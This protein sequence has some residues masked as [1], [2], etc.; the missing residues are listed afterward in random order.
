CKNRVYS[1]HFFPSDNEEEKERIAQSSQPQNSAASPFNPDFMAQRSSSFSRGRCVVG[2][3]RDMVGKSKEDDR[4]EKII[5]GL[6]RLG[7]NRR[8]INCNSLGPQYVCTTFWTIVCTNCSGVHREFTHRVKSISM[9]TFSTEEVNALQAGGNERARQ[10][11]FKAWDPVRHGFPESSNINRLRDFI[12]H[13]YVDR[14]FTGESPVDRLPRL[15]LS[16]KDDYH[17]RRGAEAIGERYGCR[18]RSGDRGTRYLY[19][20]IRSPSYLQEQ[21]K[22]PGFRT[23]SRFDVV[24]DRSRD[25]DPAIL[26]RSATQM[27]TTADIKPGRGSPVHPQNRGVSSP[28]ALRPMREFLGESA[29]ALWVGYK[30]KSNDRRAD[31]SGSLTKVTS[32]ATETS[33]TVQATK[34]KSGNPE[35]LIDFACQAAPESSEKAQTNQQANQI[36]VPKGGEIS[37]SS[38]LPKG[39]KESGVPHKNT[40]Q[41]LL[42][43]LAPPAGEPVHEPL[44]APTNV[45]SASTAPTSNASTLPTSGTPSTTHNELSHVHSVQLVG[46]FPDAGTPTIS[47]PGPAVK[48]TNNNCPSAPTVAMAPLHVVNPGDLMSTED[49]QHL[50]SSSSG[51]SPELASV[52]AKQPNEGGTRAILSVMVSD[53]GD[54]RGSSV[55]RQQFPSMPLPL[56]SAASVQESCSAQQTVASAPV[57]SYQEALP[58]AADMQDPSNNSFLQS[59]L[60]TGPAAEVSNAFTGQ[61]PSGM[62][63]KSSGRRELPADLFTSLYQSGPSPA[64]VWYDR[65]H[66]GM[67]YNMQYYPALM[68]MPVFHTSTKST[69]PFELNDDAS[70]VPAIEFPSM[71][72]L[73]GALPHPSM[74]AGLSTSSGFNYSGAYMG[75]NIYGSMQPSRIQGGGFGIGGGIYAP[76]DS[77]QNPAYQYSSSTNPNSSPNGGNPFGWNLDGA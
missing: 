52:P 32:L 18:G 44:V 76:S 67:G 23:S 49:L 73:Q 41:F 37:N 46:S 77:A 57:T 71:A 61:Q 51:S 2:W 69:N 25:Y 60:S 15:K 75:Q 24:Y 26:R 43:E 31:A 7:E 64:P 74:H 10:I 42:F 38:K 47:N 4:I 62:E 68:Q 16:D 58:Q 11:Y 17:E 9:A 55:E 72:S 6:L 59:S 12:K 66:Y 40:L 5:R 8:C 20:A 30:I 70:H 45:G 36:Y 14:R 48:L 65:P 22:S 13:V 21:S 63:Q 35:S 29:P 39:E 50:T 19:D 56:N 54:S 53:V 34:S 27:F 33:G 1:C 3:G 28:P